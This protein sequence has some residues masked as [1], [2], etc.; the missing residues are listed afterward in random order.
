M[1]VKLG[2]I[3][4]NGEQRNGEFGDGRE[5]NKMRWRQSDKA[6]HNEDTDTRQPRLPRHRN[7]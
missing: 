7:R 5:V 1:S 6:K 4:S 3:G 2:L